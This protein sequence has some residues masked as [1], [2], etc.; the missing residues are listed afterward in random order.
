MGRPEGTG[1][2]TAAH[3]RQA[4][5]GGDLPAI[6]A[7]GRLVALVPPAIEPTLADR[8]GMLHR[9]RE[10]LAAFAERRG[11]ELEVRAMPSAWAAVEALLHGEGDLALTV[12][13][14]ARRKARLSFLPP[15]GTV[16]EWLV[17]R[18]GGER[19][20]HLDAIGDAVVAVPA[21]S[22]VAERLEA[23]AGTPPRVRVRTIAVPDERTLAAEVAAGR[24]DYT[25]LS[26]PS[27]DAASD[28]FPSLE[29]VLRVTEAR[30]I[31]WAVRPDAS[32][33]QGALRT[34]LIEKALTGHTEER[35]TGDLPGMRRRGVLRV[36][37]RNNPVTYYLYK[38]APR[39]F[40]YSLVRRLADRLGLRLEMVVAPSRDALLTWLLEGRGDLVAASLT[41][42]PERAARVAFSRPYL[43]VDEILVQPAGAPPITS[44]EAL[45]GHAVH[46]RRSSSYWRTLSRLPGPI[47]LVAEDETKE[48][49]ELIDEVGQGLIP[50]TVAD[51]HILKAE[52]AWRDD[53]EGT[54]NL[55]ASPDARR[56]AKAIAFAL[57][58]TSV[59]LERA[60]DAF[61]K[62]TYRGLEYNLAF[63]QT[64]ERRRRQ[65]ANAWRKV[66]E[67]EGR[68]SPYDD[69][70][71]ATSERYGLD[72]RLMAA[73]AFQESGFDP[74]AVSWV[75][76]KGLF[77]VMPATGRAM[78]FTNLE[79]PEQGIHAGI[80][81]LRQ[82]IDRLDPRLP[83]RQR[84]RMAMAA[85]NAGLGHVQD[86]R[87][88]AARLGLDPYR[89]FGNV[90]KAMRL[91]EKPRYYRRARHGYARGRETV[92]YVSEI[93]NRYDNYVK[94]VR[95]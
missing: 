61:V 31:A 80:R 2:K 32:E 56:P 33:L 68:I 74:K 87:R 42:T 76:A 88:L 59:I 3:S 77:Q 54:L 5:L 47:P 94:L 69:L 26:R 58:K 20:A 86:A 17:G 10:A 46:V 57:R 7:R 85:Y 40:D 36:I 67:A 9:E 65:E 41:V 27:L 11:L 29:G 52:L 39:G 93:Q 34:F 66:A 50:L 18:A 64:F 37:T 4:P 89:W 51:T 14:T 79:D 19:P 23:L 6:V 95:E 91:L 82:L 43:Y 24:L 16:E 78:G 90:E 25:V 21:G 70:L 48:T 83:F 53:V 72:W 15:M 45:A 55:T 28:R 62:E 8:F 73:M 63:R 71:R 1:S 38:G 44:V 60:V 81:Y 30:E 92:R 35:F 22:A 84:V 75:G 12:P 49:E 13:V